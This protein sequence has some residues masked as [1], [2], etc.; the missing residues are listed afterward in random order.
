MAALS[1]Q[2][3]IVAAL[4]L[5]AVAGLL[6]LPWYV[7]P[8]GFWSFGWLAAFRQEDG[9]PALIQAAAHGRYWLWP[10]IPL[11]LLP[12]AAI[13]RSAAAAILLTAGSVGLGYMLV[14][15][16]LIGINGWAIPSLVD[17][18]GP[19]APQEGMGAGAVATGTAFLLML[20]AGFARRGAMRGDMFL[21]SSIAVVIAS[22]GLFVFFPVARVL[23]EAALDTEG[24]FSVSALFARLTTDDI[25]SLGCMA[26]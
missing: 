13:H 15:G 24:G 20:A 5:L 16:F 6:L 3:R 9:A 22:I 4:V 21:V 18:F 11:A 23:L 10:W 8:G 17:S 14:E 7:T 1:R 25:W 2:D 26:G 12:L 19:V